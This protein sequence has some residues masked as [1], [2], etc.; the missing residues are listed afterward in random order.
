LQNI[1]TLAACSIAQGTWV[2]L[3]N[4]AL[5]EAQMG[6]K[7]KVWFFGTYYTGISKKSQAECTKCAART[8]AVYVNKFKYFAGQWQPKK[9][10]PVTKWVGARAVKP[11][12]K[13][14]MVADAAKISA[15]FERFARISVNSF[16]YGLYSCAYKT[17]AEFVL[18]FAC[19]CGVD[20]SSGGCL[21]ATNPTAK[22]FVPRAIK[23]VA[24]I[25]ENTYVTFNSGTFVGTGVVTVTVQ[26]KFAVAVS[27]TPSAETSQQ[28]T[29][30]V[31]LSGNSGQLVNN[32]GY[33]IGQAI[34]GN[35]E[36]C[37]AIDPTIPTTFASP[38]FAVEASPG[39]FQKDNTVTITSNTDSSKICGVV[40]NG[41]IV[42]YAA[43]TTAPPVGPTVGNA[44]TV[45][46]SM[47]LL[48]IL[49]LL[50]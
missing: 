46:L 9:Y 7:E 13:R 4:Q 15:F 37:I 12:H 50:F 40:T 14:V 42:Y 32:N 38:T 8:S 28:T 41:N 1:N 3:S 48:V 22:L 47:L 25:S 18:R 10:L 44:N 45:A 43:M 5:C 30:V 11:D 19:A 6:C 49:A 2:D 34:S 17:K 31:T 33:S 27:T 24:E 26:V 16:L 23:H 36:I 29:G 35:A 21:A 20:K 39:V